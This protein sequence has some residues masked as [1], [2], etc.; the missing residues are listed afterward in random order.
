MKLVQYNKY[1]FCTV[2]T[3]GLVLYQQSI[4]S[5]NIAYAPMHFQLANEK[6]ICWFAVAFCV[7]IE[8][9]YSWF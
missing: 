7:I 5:Y 2:D 3:N 6:N 4:S 8:H 1:L 9:W